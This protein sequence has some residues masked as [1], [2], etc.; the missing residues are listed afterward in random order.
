MYKSSIKITST[1]LSVNQSYVGES[2]EKKIERIVNN[3]EKI[4]DGAPI[5]YTD[6]AD[7]V[8]AAYNIRTDR[9]EVALDGITAMQKANLAK[10]D[11]NPNIKNDDK[12]DLKIVGDKS[13]EGQADSK[14]Q[15]SE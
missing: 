1:R 7:G 13:I 8:L 5:I 12:A 14:S 10:R 6:R 2:I 15:T 11:N 9:F 3:Q 4:T